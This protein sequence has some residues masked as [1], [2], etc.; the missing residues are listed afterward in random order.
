MS[1]RAGN[2]PLRKRK[3]HVRDIDDC[4]D[5]RCGKLRGD[6]IQAV[7][8]ERGDCLQPQRWDCGATAP[9]ISAGDHRRVDDRTRRRWVR[10][11]VQTHGPRLAA[12]NQLRHLRVW[13]PGARGTRGTEPARERELAAQVAAASVQ[14][15]LREMVAGLLLHAQLALAEPSIAPGLAARLQ[16]I[17]ELAAGVGK[18][19][20]DFSVRASP[21]E[22]FAVPKSPAANP[23]PDESRRRAVATDESRR[24]LIATMDARKPVIG[25]LTSGSPVV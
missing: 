2:D 12:R 10:Y 4:R 1:R 7:S 24:S 21:A 5:G 25:G 23:I 13:P 6:A 9:R 15:N 18:R 11:A 3:R 16:G 14:N 20:D 22:P 19:L 17:V 8:D